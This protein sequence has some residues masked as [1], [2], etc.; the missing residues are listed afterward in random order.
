MYGQQHATRL[1]SK[2]T[3]NSEL[4][5]AVVPQGNSVIVSCTK[6]NLQE[7]ERKAYLKKLLQ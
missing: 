5:L 1:H 3:Q 6:S 7:K 4:P 2:I